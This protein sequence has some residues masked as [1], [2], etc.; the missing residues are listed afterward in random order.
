M[1][2]ERMTTLAKNMVL[3]KLTRA[4]QTRQQLADYLSERG[5]AEE[6]VSE[7]LGRMT[8]VGLINDAE[9]AAMFVR[10][11]RASR[12]L[13]PRVLAQELR[14]RGVD[15]DI[16]TTELAAISPT[17]DRDLAKSLVAKKL[18]ATARLDKETRIR[19]LTS[20]LVRKGFSAGLAFEVVREAIGELPAED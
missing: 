11:K 6:I 8:D 20:M 19:R 2:P 7:V 4:P 3:R 17:D 16:I 5:I 10:A 18:M 1:T 14:Q 12:G 13:A 15:D 9:F